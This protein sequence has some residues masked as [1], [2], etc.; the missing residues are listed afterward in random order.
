MNGN[1]N[2][3][4]RVVQFF[5]RKSSLFVY[6][7]KQRIEYLKLLV[8]IIHMNSSYLK[9]EIIEGPLFESL[10]KIIDSLL[11][12]V[13]DV[14]EIYDCLSRLYLYKWNLLKKILNM[15]YFDA[16]NRRSQDIFHLLSFMNQLLLDWISSNSINEQNIAVIEKF[17]EYV[18]DKSLIFL[19]KKGDNILIET[20]II[21][22][23]KTVSVM[24]SKWNIDLFL[25]PSIKLMSLYVNNNS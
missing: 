1:Y 19:M 2:E 13:I 5:K 16:Y 15:L 20:A 21:C 4:E 9:I 24:K 10:L 3:I 23:F 6:S 8:N 22:F 7:H 14:K 17:I 18:D 12:T 25:L 11:I